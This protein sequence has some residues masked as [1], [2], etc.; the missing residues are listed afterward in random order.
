MSNR[1]LNQYLQRSMGQMILLLVLCCTMLPLP[2]FA[3]PVSC[4]WYQSPMVKKKQ[5]LC[6]VETASP[7]LILDS[8]VGVGSV[9]EEPKAYGLSHFLEH[10]LFKGSAG[11]PVGALDRFFEVQGGLTNAATSYEFTHYYQVLPTLNWQESLAAHIA[12]VK[13]PTFPTKEVDLERDVVVQEM[14]RAY[15]SP[16]AQLFNGLHRLFLNQTPYEHPVLGT[17]EIIKNTPIEQISAYYRRYY[18]PEN[19]VLFMASNIPKS[20]IIKTLQL[21]KPVTLH[22][23]TDKRPLQSAWQVPTTGPVVVEQTDAVKQPLFVVTMPHPI[24]VTPLHQLAL[25]VVWQLVFAE[26]ANFFQQQLQPIQGLDSYFSGTHDLKSAPYGYWGA[27]VP[28]ATT[29]T[30]VLKQWEALRQ[31]GQPLINKMA[32]ISETQLQQEKQKMLQ[33][34]ALLAEDPDQATQFYGEAWTTGQW[35]VAMRY[36]QLVEQ[37]SLADIHQALREIMANPAGAFILLPKNVS[38]V[39]STTLSTWQ[40]ALTSPASLEKVGSSNQE[41]LKIEGASRKES[42]KIEHISLQGQQAT[43]V[44]LPISNAPTVALRMGFQFTPTTPQQYA[45]RLVLSNLLGVETQGFTEQGWLQWLATRGI[46]A[47]VGI[48]PDSLVVAAKGLS[49]QQGDVRQA[50]TGFLMPTW[51]RGVFERERLKVIQG[52]ETMPQHP[53]AYL[54]QALAE[55]AFGHSVYRVNRVALLEALKDLRLEAVQALWQQLQNHAPITVV[56]TGQYTAGWLAPVLPTWLGQVG[57]SSNQQQPAA[58]GKLMLQSTSSG[59]T[60]EIASTTTI[61]LPVAVHQKT[62]S[63]PGQKTVWLGWSF[64]LPPATASEVLMPLRVLNAYLGQG[65]SSVLFQEIREKQGLAYEV[66]TKLDLAE[67]GSM[68]TVYLGT[69]PDKVV[70]AK[71]I[72]NRILQHLATEPLSDI[73]LQEAKRK[74]NGRFELS[75][76]TANDRAALLLRF[77]MLGLGATFDERYTTLVEAVTAA[78]IQQAVKQYITPAQ[79]VMVELTAPTVGK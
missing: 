18:T 8:W 31:N 34:F 54:Q 12:L 26:Q 59:T 48:E 41:T 24:A 11:Y 17:P 16:F 69:A 64:P 20:D 15:N 61:P 74:V 45:A 65:M 44:S 37:L 73:A 79:G 50:L 13:A 27:M 77:E 33:Q 9:N 6:I 38:A 28:D 4:Y 7:Q 22:N 78:D 46:E 5:P 19:T 68:F 30:T 76:S 72:V 14:S 49:S 21:G 42:E 1:F 39:D 57:R 3:L 58:T 47:T 32:W 36:P 40:T 62:L 75:H 51:S 23:S 35:D 66:A 71:A 63:V 10:L 29:I 53:Q 2:V 56:Q 70:Q 52:L 67:K 60:K 25:G 43:L 55:Q